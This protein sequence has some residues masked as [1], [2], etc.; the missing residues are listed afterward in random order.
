MCAPAGSLGQKARAVDIPPQGATRGPPHR[1]GD[2]G[3]DREDR[4][5]PAEFHLTRRDGMYIL[6][7]RLD[8]EGAARYLHRPGTLAHRRPT[9][10]DGADP[11]SHARRMGDALVDLAGTPPRPGPAGLRRDPHP[12]HHHHDPGPAH[13]TCRSRTR[14]GDGGAAEIV[15]GT[16]REPI[17]AERARRLACDARILPSVMNGASLILDHGAARRTA[18][19]AQRIALALRDKGCTAP[20]CDRP[21]AWCEATTWFPGGSARTPTWTTWSWSATPTTTCSTTTAGP[22]PWRTAAPSGTHHPPAPPPNRPNHPT[23]HP[24]KH[25]RDAGPTDCRSGGGIDDRG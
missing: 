6:G 23:R 8:P 16:I 19:P 1:L 5:V 2:P 13:R 20:F 15:G 7:R 21:A 3:P 22:S 14:H 17:S 4:A 18:S 9:T 11:R 24:T 25:H 12:G 10:L